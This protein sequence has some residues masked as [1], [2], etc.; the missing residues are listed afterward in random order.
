MNL[1]YDPTKLDR[2]LNKFYISASD[3]EIKNML[4]DTSFKSLNELFS[5]IKED[6]KKM[7][8]LE[9]MGERLEYDQLSK[10]FMEL[11]SKN[12]IRKSFLGD[13]VKDFN[14]N[15]IVS[16]ICGLRGLTT[17]YTPYQPERSQGTL[18]SLWIYSNM[19]SRLTGFEAINASLY[20]R[21]T[22]LYEAI[23]TAKKTSKSQSNTILVSEGIHPNDIEVIETLAKETFLE[24]VK[25]PVSKLT[26]LTDIT[27]LKELI[28]KNVPFGLAFSQVNCFGNIEEFDKITDIA[29]SNNLKT[30][31]NIDPIHLQRGGLKGHRTSVQTK[32]VSTLSLEKDNTLLSLQ[33]SED[34]ELVFSA[35]GIMRKTNYP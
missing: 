23:L 7:D 29:K 32:R 28:E 18:W 31:A 26:G 33:T 16:K 12:K 22:A 27:K 30:I 19:I 6:V 11:A 35:S 3:D 1:P 25:V 5:H 8:Q 15:P 21:S 20:D 14:I 13:S 17:A 2:E 24:I 9:T 10:F 4:K 34:R